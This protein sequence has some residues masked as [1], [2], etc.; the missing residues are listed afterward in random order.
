MG[1]PPSRTLDEGTWGE[2]LDLANVP[3]TDLDPEGLREHLTWHPAEEPPP[4]QADGQHLRGREWR[5]WVHERSPYVLAGLSFG[6]DSLAMVHGLLDT[7]PR[8]R[9]IGYWLY[10]HPRLSWQRRQLNYYRRELGI[11]IYAVAHRTL[12]MHLEDCLYQ[13][14]QNRAVIWQHDV[15]NVPY[16]SV[17]WAIA[18]D[19][20]ILH[21]R[22]WVA[23][24]VRAA[25]S[26]LR[27]IVI[28]R[29]GPYNLT[30]RTFYPIWEERKADV[31]ARIKDLGIKLP[32][33]YHLWGR[34]F[35]GQDY[36]F[37]KPLAEH[38]PEDYARLR[39]MFP[40]MDTGFIRRG[41][42][43]PTIEDHDHE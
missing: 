38:F 7:W 33:D 25:D 27:R 10:P 29:R 1:N 34:T 43:P 42:E 41:E 20:G 30:Q 2:W 9:I 32:C 36:R 19:A 14:P 21:E 40:L 4:L 35:D 18:A 22:P 16:E 11:R 3:A 15:R 31:V 39:E 6:K 8:D 26:P 13:P 24:G 28:S 5:E 23:Q 17:Y 12:W 37:I